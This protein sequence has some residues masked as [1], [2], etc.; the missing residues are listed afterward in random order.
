MFHGRESETS[1]YSKKDYADDR[2]SQ[3]TAATRSHNQWYTE[4]NVWE[5][6]FSQMQSA[7]RGLLEAAAN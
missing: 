2:G 4:H 3:Q 1:H 7:I 5:L 6:E